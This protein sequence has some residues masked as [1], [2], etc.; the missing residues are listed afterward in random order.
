M[1]SLFDSTP[2]QRDPE[3]AK[4]HSVLAREAHKSL[5]ERVRELAEKYPE[6]VPELSKESL[7]DTDA[8][9]TLYYAVALKVEGI[10]V[11]NLDI[12]FSDTTYT[13]HGEGG[14]IAIG[15][16][17]SW[18]TAIF[19]YPLSVMSDWEALFTV[20]YASLVTEVALWGLHGEYIGIILAGG[21]GLGGGTV[22]GRGE[23]KSSR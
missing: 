8:D 7:I 9:R 18:G 13:F 16:N 17:I 19:N 21:I 20:N 5:K 3:L 10:I 12:S 4:A 22:G 6:S 14:G 23:F 15:G 11:V 2:D 1:S